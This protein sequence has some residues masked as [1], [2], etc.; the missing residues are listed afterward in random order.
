[1][2]GSLKADYSLW[3]LCLGGITHFYDPL[4]EKG[5][6][7]FKSAKTKG[8]QFFKKAVK[9][10]KKGKIKRSM[11]FLGVAVH[12]LADT[13]IPAHTKAVMHIPSLFQ[14]NLEIYMNKNLQLVKM[15]IN[16]VKVAIKEDLD[17]YFDDLAHVSKDF[18]NGRVGLFPFLSRVFG[19]KKLSKEELENQTKELGPLAISYTMGLLTKFNEKIK[20]S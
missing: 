8:I 11:I 7:L 9:A 20:P 1:M 14:D 19:V 4:K 2:K 5:Y 6:F 10:Y 16:H 15:Y 3:H 18:K 17:E 13:A 12:L